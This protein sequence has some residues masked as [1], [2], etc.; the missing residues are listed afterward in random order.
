[1]TVVVN[2]GDDLW[3]AGVRLHARLRL[4]ALRARGRE[5]HRARLGSRRRDRTRRRRAAR[6]GRRAGRGSRSATSTS[7]RTSRAPR[8]LREGA[9]PSQVVDPPASARWPLGVRL[10]PVTDTEVDTYVLVADADELD[11]ERELHFQEWWTRYRAAL[12]A[13]AFRQPGYRARGARRRAS[14]RRSSAPTSCSSR[15]RTRSSRSA[16]SSRCPAS[17]RRSRAT[18]RRSS[19]S[20]RSSAAG[21][22]AAWPTPACR[23]SASRRPP[24]RS[25][26]TTAR[27]RD[28]GLL[29]GW[30]VDEADAAASRAARGCRPRRGIR[31]PVDARPR[32]VGRA[33]RRG[34]RPRG[35]HPRRAVGLTRVRR[36][37][38]RAA[39]GGCHRAA[40]DWRG[41]ADRRARAR[42]RAALRRRGLHVGRRRAPDP[43]ARRDDD[44]LRRSRRS[45][46]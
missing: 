44:Q 41:A 36:V 33:R 39:A 30:L 25:A 18:P 19:A 45:C 21:S 9:T 24:R 17:A 14:S 31:A 2:T 35:A 34:D 32:H 23:R 43:G 12:P 20:R 1:M 10:L 3:L 11:G 5:R 29:D 22:C 16:R 28:G 6:V 8:W 13:I 40:P 26:G 38:R 37:A 42:S 46:S 7:A 4:D 15:R 27:A